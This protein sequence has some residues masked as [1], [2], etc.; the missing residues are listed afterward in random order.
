MDNATQTIID[1]LKRIDITVQDGVAQ[2]RESEAVV[3][4]TVKNSGQSNL[5]EHERT[6]DS[7]AVAIATEQ[8]NATIEINDGVSRAHDETITHLNRIAEINQQEQKETRLE[9]ER[10][11][12]E[13]EEQVKQ[14]T[15]E[16]RILKIE[17]AES[18]KTVVDSIGKF[19]VNEQKK[20]Q[21]HSNAKFNLWVAKEIILK[22]LLVSINLSRNIRYPNHH[23]QTLST[24]AARL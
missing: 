8:K 16:I 21:E 23:I 6:R 14:L 13:A 18:V 5:A 24:T 22:K 7:L 4:N 11:R 2:V 17:I 10:I 15:E 9:M 12:V 3:V 1:R 19:P 20:L